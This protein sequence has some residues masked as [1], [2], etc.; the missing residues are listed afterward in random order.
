MKQKIFIMDSGILI[1]L[2]MNGLLYILE[3]LK[4]DFNG[5]FIITKQVK[6]ETIDNPLN[7]Q[8]FELDAL[9]IKALLEN[10]TIELPDSLNIPEPLLNR[11]TAEL[12]SIANHLLTRNNEPIKIVSEGEISCLALSSIL[13]EQDIENI[14]GI[15]ERTTRILSEKPENLEEL[16]SRKLHTAVK[17]STKNFSAFKEFKFIR[18]PEIV[19]TAYKK[20]ILRIK[21]RRALEA[22]LYATKFKGSSISWNEIRILK[23]M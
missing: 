4:K 8:K 5:K 20:G 9:E 10:K 7:V 6:Y 21:D 14:I 19:Y 17:L 2:A 13:S 18:S 12:M 16:M 3:D 11:K 15:D 23:K 22:A 1:N